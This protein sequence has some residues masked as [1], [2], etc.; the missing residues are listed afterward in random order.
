MSL[1]IKSVVWYCTS[2]NSAISLFVTSNAKYS[3]LSK[4]FLALSKTYIW[5]AQDVQYLNQE[6]TIT[7]LPSAWAL[8]NNSLLNVVSLAIPLLL[9]TNKQKIKI[10]IFFMSLYN[11]YFS[12][13]QSFFKIIFN[14]YY[15]IGK[16]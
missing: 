5:L 2:N 13:L 10:K 9:K 16:K 3:M 8:S 14:K 11:N 15:A 6:L 12:L 7:T 4:S 1:K